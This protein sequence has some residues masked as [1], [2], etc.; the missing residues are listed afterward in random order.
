MISPWITSIKNLSIQLPALCRLCG[1][2]HRHKHAL[3]QPCC[4]LIEPLGFACRSCATPLPDPT[5]ALCGACGIHPPYLDNVITAYRFTEPLRT[6]LHAF[7]YDAALCLTSFLTEI[8]L[9][10]KPEDYHTQCLIPVPLHKHRLQQR[11][12]NQAALLAL[13]I[14][15]QIK[16]PCAFHH[17]HKIVSTLPQAGLN[18]KERKRNLKGAFKVQALPYQHVTLIDDLYTTGTTAN[19]IA[20]LLKQQGVQQVDLWCCARVCR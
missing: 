12:F 7:K 16:K 8:M 13:Q 9:N 18:A 1:V 10:A 5:P 11:G 17:C 6:L 4:S 2:Y 14:G 19:E 3:C 15:K 20:R